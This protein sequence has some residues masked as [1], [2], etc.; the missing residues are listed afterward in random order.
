MLNLLSKKSLKLNL[1]KNLKD[2]FNSINEIIVILDF[3][4]Q[5]RFFNNYALKALG[6]KEQDILGKDYF[7][8]FIP[9]DIRK[10]LK[11]VFK[12]L[13]TKDQ[14]FKNYENEI[15]KK[16]GTYLSIA[17]RNSYLNIGDEKFIFSIGFDITEKK[18]TQE[19]LQTQEIKEKN[20]KNEWKL[21]FDAINDVVVIVDKDLNVLQANKK[22]QELSNIKLKEGSLVKCFSYFQKRK[23]LCEGCLIKKA[24]ETK[25]PVDITLNNLFEDKTFHL[26]FYPIL[27]K[28][29]EVKKIVEYG[30]DITNEEKFKIKNTFLAD[31]IRYS[32]EP[33]IIIDM[34]SNVMEWNE[35]AEKLFG[36]KRE[37]MIGKSV[38]KI[39]PQ[40]K[41]EETRQCFSY[42]LN[43]NFHI[44]ETKRI[45]KNKKIIPV[46][47]F[48]NL[49]LDKDNKPYA[50]SVFTRDIT[51]LKIQEKELKKHIIE[52]EKKNKALKVLERFVVSRELKMLELKKEIQELNKKIGE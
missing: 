15:L 38:M 41:Y 25:K 19:I 7:N 5:I 43:Q 30:R 50:V 14:E 37:E 3:N 23:D 51:G 13:I 31:I 48:A 27:D 46:S 39:I 36:Y 16:D 20:E 28:D 35:G 2:L 32:L 6:Y 47:V 10:R 22:A 49:I 11:I 33:I 45:T 17:W 4:G 40:D 24:I 52:L 9:K 18:K 44:F 29:G 21:T 1:D 8:V 12:S 34:N 42:I 26:W